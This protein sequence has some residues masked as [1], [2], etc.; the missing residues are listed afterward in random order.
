MEYGNFEIS[1]EEA[2]PTWLKCSSLSLTAASI[3]S[4]PMT[5]TSG[6]CL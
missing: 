4:G 6:F 5:L 3:A 2:N 1:V